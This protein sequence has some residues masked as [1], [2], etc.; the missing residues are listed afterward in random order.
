[1][2]LARPCRDPVEGG[3]HISSAHL[4][5]SG[6][7]PYVEAKEVE[8]CSPSRNGQVS[9]VNER[10]DGDGDIGDLVLQTFSFTNPV[11]GEARRQAIVCRDDNE[12]C[13]TVAVRSSKPL[14]VA[15]EANR[16]CSAPVRP[17]AALAHP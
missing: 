2:S 6:A 8:F 15:S 9:I 14:V 1:M 5:L 7:S 17:C 12:A 3:Q 4:L 13:T 11:L 10:L 16:H